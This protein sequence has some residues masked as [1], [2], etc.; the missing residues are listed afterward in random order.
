M[1]IKD[2]PWSARSAIRRAEQAPR[3]EAAPAVS[4]NGHRKVEEPSKA[5][6]R[7]VIHREH[8]ILPYKNASKDIK[9]Q[10]GLTI[11]VGLLLSLALVL[12]FFRAPVQGKS[13]FE[14]T[15][16][17][18]ENV[19]MEEIRQTK[20]EM[21]APPPPRPPVPIEVPDDEVI[22]DV[23]LNLD[24]TLDISE[25]ISNIPPPPPVASDDDAA[26]VEE[27]IFVIVEQ[28]P[29][30]IGGT[31]A[32]YQYLEYPEMARKAG[33]E[34]L[35]VVQ[36]VVETDGTPTDPQVVRSPGPILDEA[37]LKAVMQL[38]FKPG[39]QRGRA[40]RVRYALPVRFRLSER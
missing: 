20:Q 35:V 40:V 37:A 22:E 24:A 28:M 30:I 34:G 3:D 6:T 26:D 10:Y 39:M 13:E 32:I 19:Q 29:E 15:L 5:E 7:T 36:V 33:L 16:A 2:K 11:Q 8:S 23:E 38:R 25:P 18:Q 31:Q 14:I 12:G 4:G 21:R 27:E 1:A 17:E 9:R